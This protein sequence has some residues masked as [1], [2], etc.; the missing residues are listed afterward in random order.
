MRAYQ[1]PKGGAGIDALVQVER[2]DPK[3][4][5]RQVLVKVS[6]C[7]L[8]FRDLGI[9][10]GSYRMPVR[11]NVIPLSDGA[12][13]VVEVGPGVTRVKVGDRVAGC[14]FQRWPGG[15]PPP[16]V[17]S[18]A[19]GG[20]IDGM[21]AEYAVLEEDG[22]V[23]IPRA[24]VARGRR[25]AALRRRHRLARHDGARQA[26]RRPDRAAAGHRRRL[27]FRPATRP[28]DGHCRRSSPRRA[29]KSSRARRCS[30]PRTA[31]TTRPRPTG[32][33]R[34]WNSPAAAASITWSKS[35]ARRRCR[36]RSAPSASA[37]RS[38]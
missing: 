13:E 18:S 1:L 2:P 23:K 8:N 19:L 5:Y 37:A 20:S 32:T 34:R 28:R 36:A 27:D 30:A 3:P 12:G 15:E 11:E 17:H 22:V 25:D 7:S 29:T 10:R 14:F 9:V 33:R 35:A 4:A 6:A 16:D 31:S 21:L 38:A 24:S 26:H